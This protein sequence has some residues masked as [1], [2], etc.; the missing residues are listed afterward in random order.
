MI[1]ADQMTR[2]A[3]LSEGQFV[4]APYADPTESTINVME[5][6]MDT[7]ERPRR[8]RRRICRSSART[9]P[10]L[11]MS[12]RRPVLGARRRRSTSETEQTNTTNC[13]MDDVKEDAT[14]LERKK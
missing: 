4:R 6:Q 13:R 8:T 14:A 7:N 10:R 5:K 3:G 1:A 2:L 12:R 11:L 9:N